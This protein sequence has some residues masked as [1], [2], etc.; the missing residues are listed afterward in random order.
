[1]YGPDPEIADNVPVPTPNVAS[2]VAK[3]DDDSDNVNVTVTVSPDFKFPLPLRVIETVGAVVST[4]M[5]PVD[6]T[7]R[8]PAASDAYTL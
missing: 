4:V 2:P 5:V 8:F 1:V 3:F 6:A 7:D